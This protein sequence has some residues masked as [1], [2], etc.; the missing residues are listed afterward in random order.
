MIIPTIFSG[1]E[2][3][4]IELIDRDKLFL[5]I[6][7]FSTILGNT[8]VCNSTWVQ[9]FLEMNIEYA[10]YYWHSLPGLSVAGCLEDWRFSLLRHHLTTTELYTPHHTTRSVSSS[11]SP[12]Q[13][14]PIWP[15]QSSLTLS[16]VECDDSTWIRTS[17]HFIRPPHHSD[18]SC[19]QLDMYH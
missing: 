19:H 12:S 15:H 6:G 7:G 1:W 4:L 10:E 8:G 17:G 9:R 18:L 3:D 5:I 13:P 16:R 11:S 2:F 14:Q